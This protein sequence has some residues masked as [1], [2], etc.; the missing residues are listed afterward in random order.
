M[1][2]FSK[3]N[4][5]ELREFLYNSY[6]HDAKLV[7]INYKCGEDL[8]EVELLNPIF[9][10]GYHFIFSSIRVFL[11][12]KGDWNGRRD[13]IVSFTAEEEFSYLRRYLPKYGEDRKNSLYFLLQMFSGG[14]LH[15]VSDYVIAD[16]WTGVVS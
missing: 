7:N 6:V 1:P 13:I 11:A 4:A 14:E 12:T 10:V 9:N 16:S 2:G 8:A 15:I 3:S 5:K